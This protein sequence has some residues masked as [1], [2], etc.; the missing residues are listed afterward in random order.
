MVAAGFHVSNVQG[1]P[2]AA[3][4]GTA[5]WKPWFCEQISLERLMAA[6][7]RCSAP[8]GVGLDGSAKAEATAAAPSPAA[9]ASG[10]C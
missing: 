10:W 6:V 9:A 7:T 8:G 3:L 1:N 4:A 5:G 2:R